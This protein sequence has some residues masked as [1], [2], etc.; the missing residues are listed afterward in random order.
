MTL[1]LPEALS[2]DIVRLDPDLAWPTVWACVKSFAMAI[3]FS[4]ALLQSR[5]HISYAWTSI[6]GDS[7]FGGDGVWIDSGGN[8]P[9][10]PRVKQL[11]QII[12]DQAAANSRRAHRAETLRSMGADRLLVVPRVGERQLTAWWNLTRLDVSTVGMKPEKLPCTDN[13]R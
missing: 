8:S 5:V 3:D 10:V 1:R 9:A 4:R 11:I 6:Y 2:D 7:F 12:P 13:S